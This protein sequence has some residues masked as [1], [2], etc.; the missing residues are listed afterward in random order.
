[1]K[2][3]VERSILINADMK[4]VRELVDDFNNWNTWSPWTIVEPGCKVK[5]K[6]EVGKVGHEMSWD[7]EII[8][9]GVNTLESA[10]G[11]RLNYDLRFIKP[12]KSK[13]KAAFEFKEVKDGVEVTWTM[14]GSMPFFLFF[15]I[16]MMRAWIGMDYDRGLRMMK[17]MA[18]KGKVDVDTTNEGIKPYEG[19]SYVG[20]KRTCPVKNCGDYMKM[21][22]GKLMELLEKSG[23]QAKHWG[24][25]YPKFDMVKQTFTYIAFM[26]AENLEGVE[27]GAEVVS[28]EIKDGKVLEIKHRGSYDFLGNAWSMGMMYLRAKKIKQKDVPF[29]Y[30]W[31]NPNEV[32]LRDCKTSIYFPVKAQ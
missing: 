25:L 23:K 14:D 18:E 21:D 3:K 32:E 5:V 2:Y 1:M 31:N 10:E 13:S 6:G 12:F 17:E 28:G 29:E 30:Y 22:F 11:N 15:M 16:P 20:V 27:L 4:K 9:A 8:G 7:G 26:S 24:S 19:F